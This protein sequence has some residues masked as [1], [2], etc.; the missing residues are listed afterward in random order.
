MMLV[1][2]EIGTV[3]PVQA[4]K[5]AAMMARSPALIHCDAVQAFGKMPLSAAKL[6]I[7]LMTVSGHKIHAPKGVGALYIADRIK[8]DPQL[9][10]GGQQSKI[11]PGTES[12]PLIAALGQAAENAVKNMAANAQKVSE[13][14]QTLLALLSEVEGV[15]INSPD[16][17][18]MPYILNCSAEGYRSETMLH[19][20]EAEGIFISSGSACSMGAQSQH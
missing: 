18:C 3:M 15:T 19:F 11:R 2:N 4:A 17:N 14:K 16:E 1:N 12:V 20:M 10:G 6:G 5:R 8:I 7:D 9:F 13:A